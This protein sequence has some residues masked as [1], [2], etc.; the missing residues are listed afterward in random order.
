M[1]GNR[2]EFERRQKRRYTLKTKR[3]T[4]TNRRRLSLVFS[5]LVICFLALFIR[6]IFIDITLG[7]T[8]ERNVLTILN[9]G[10]D[11]IPY[12]RGDITDRNGTVLA[13]SEKQY[14]LILD[15]YV[16]NESKT[17]N[18]KEYTAYVLAK[19][20]GENEEKMLKKINDNPTKRY[21]VIKKEMTYDKR[22]A[23]DEFMNSED[24]ED[25]KIIN[26]V[27]NTIWFEEGYNRVYPFSTLACDVI[28]FVTPDEN[29]SNYGLE[30]SYNSALTGT[31][32]RKYGYI[33]DDIDMQ[34]VTRQPENG[35]TVV[36]TLDV[37]IQR[38]AENY[39]NAFMEDVG[40]DNV[41]AIV[42]NPNNG[43]V[44]GMASAPV[45]DCNNPHDDT[46]GMSAARIKYWIDKKNDKASGY[47]YTEADLIYTLWRNYCV[48]DSFEPGSTAK[49][50]TVAYALDQADVKDE[51]KFDCDGGQ[52]YPSDGTYVSCN[53]VHGELDLSGTLIHS[54]NDAMMQIADIMGKEKFLAMQQ[55][56]GIGQKTGIDLP[57]EGS[58]NSMVFH[59]DTL[60][61][62]E[63]W[64]SSFG[65]GFNASMIQMATAFCSIINGGSYYK[66][67]IVKEILDDSGSKMQ[68]F[69]KT[70]ERMTVSGATSAWMRDTLYRTVEEGTGKPAKVPGYKI[71]GKTGT[72]EV[73]VR[74]SDDRTVSFIGF[75]PVDDPQIMVYVVVDRAYVDDQGQSEF[76]SKIAGGIFS[77]VLPYLEIFP[78]E[79]VTEEDL[80]T[81]EQLHER[82]EPEYDNTQDEAADD[83]Q[84][85]DDEQKADD[86]VTDDEVSDEVTDDEEVV[87]DEVTD[88]EVS[89]EEV[90]DDEVT[91]D[92]VSDEEVV[93]DEWQADD[94]VSDDE[95]QADDE[96]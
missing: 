3:F 7:E 88:D 14:K 32:G 64:T 45:F 36:S 13:T 16:A 24:P 53:N 78:T 67:H 81:F 68:V 65:Q 90:V 9:Y 80:E 44:L 79:P 72:S 75:A 34:N 60:G 18:T 30:G 27:K 89:D 21:I 8:Y 11:V 54:C 22:K 55:T 83:K 37:N 46:V 42:M 29:T 85:T 25:L 43:E 74:G 26:A 19:Y 38:I 12:K 70:L 1:A 52:T 51:D 33:N 58:W 76:A 62:I 40:A 41:A 77:E 96:E 73:G 5:F 59:E 47:K 87:D 4:R 28:G 15:A 82:P 91:D 2:S 95:W 66:P 92:E 17:E 31:D 56:F 23:F 71:G 39:V 50:M 20:F 94:E 69:E 57:G 63:L 49:T 86:E 61:P 35:K 93:D 6:L 48:D 10:S 84:K